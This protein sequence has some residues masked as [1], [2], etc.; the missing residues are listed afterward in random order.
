MAKWS[1]RKEEAVQKDDNDHQ[2]TAGE[3]RGCK[4]VHVLAELDSADMHKCGVTQ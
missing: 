2:V 3:I 4:G 1:V